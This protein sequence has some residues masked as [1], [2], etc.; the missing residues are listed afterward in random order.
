MNDQ[1]APE[2][3]YPTPPEDVYPLP[4]EAPVAVPAAVVT[5]TIETLQRFEEFFRR[6]A[7]PAVQAELR[8]FCVAQGWHSVC[9]AEALL[10]DLGWDALAL[11]HTLDGAANPPAAPQ[12]PR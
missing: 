5:S 7:S 8:A 12:V 3:A 11:R 4:D 1:T 9:G 6:H 10:D 2:D